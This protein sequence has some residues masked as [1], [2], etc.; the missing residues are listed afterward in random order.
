MTKKTPQLR[1][2]VAA[3]GF[4]LVA[5]EWD[6]HHFMQGAMEDGVPELM[7]FITLGYLIPDTPRGIVCVAQSW[8][9]RNEE[10][11]EVLTLAKR[12]VIGI[13][14]LVMEGGG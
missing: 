13:T 4:H 8:N 14:R 6:D 12:D 7:R 10:Y 5:V 1:S 2:A 11:E 9:V 3:D